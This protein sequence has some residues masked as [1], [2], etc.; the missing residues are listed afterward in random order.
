MEKTKVKI[1]EGIEWETVAWFVGLML[2]ASILPRFIHNQFI[3]GPIINATLFLAAGTMGIGPAILIGLVPSVVAL[4]SGLLPAPLAPMVPFIM[5]SN[6]ILIVV[7]AYVKKI[8]FGAGA[9]VASFTK[10]AFLYFTV[11]F[12]VRMISNHSIAAKAAATMMA[13]PQLVTA[14][15][16]AVIAFGILKAV[17]KVD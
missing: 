2:V 5:I 16:G 10:Y 4:S 1:L 12:V 3:T 6:T 13:W 11:T 14:L 7:F 9:V 15:A 17:Q 8:N